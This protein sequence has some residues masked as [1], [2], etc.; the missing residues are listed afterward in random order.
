MYRLVAI[1]LV[2]I[3]A[4][5][6]SGQSKTLLP[7]ARVPSTAVFDSFRSF[8]L[9]TACDEKGRLY[10]KLLTPDGDNGGSLLRFSKTGVQEAAFDMSAAVGFNVFAVRPK[11]GVSTVQDEQ[12]YSVVNFG[13]DGKRESMVH[14]DGAHFFPSQLALFPSG[15]VFLS[16]IQR[17]TRESPGTYKAFTAVY[18]SRGHLVKQLSL[19]EDNEIE[20]AIE[21]GDARYAG[22]P[23]Q[24]NKGVT[25][26]MAVSGDDGNV[27]LMRRTS[28]ASVYV[29]SSTGEVVRKLVIAPPFAGQMPGGMQ[30]SQNKIALM[31]R[32]DCTSSITCEGAASYTVVDAITGE[33]LADYS[34]GDGVGGAFAC[35]AS[36]PERFF[37]L[38]M[39][40]KHRIEILEARPK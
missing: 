3:A 4:S 32:R 39:S 8:A 26:G 10:V 27:Y 28:P 2:C 23:K 34:S 33:K 16:G 22:S 24:G 14:L 20:R 6:T 30:V 35:Y 40:E 21:A 38:Q 37:F 19:D 5:P 29:I 36:E 11:G 1:T 9:P 31:F 13:P 12:G 15:E 17:G 7:A 18:D 25:L